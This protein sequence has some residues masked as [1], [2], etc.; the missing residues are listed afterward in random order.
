MLALLVQHAVR[1][2]RPVDKVST[3]VLWASAVKAVGT[4]S[5][6]GCNRR[7]FVTTLCS[8]LDLAPTGKIW[9]DEKVVSGWVGVGFC[10]QKEGEAL[11]AGKAF[12]DWVGAH[13][14]RTG[15]TDDRM[16]IAVLWNLMVKAGGDPH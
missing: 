8:L 6:L 14:A 12:S 15:N 16:S 2:N 11:P 9:A 10:R 1:T 13:I 7:T 4:N 5:P 3:A